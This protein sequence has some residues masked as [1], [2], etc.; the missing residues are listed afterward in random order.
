MAAQS[1]RLAFRIIISAI[2]NHVIMTSSIAITNMSI[3]FKVICYVAE[4]I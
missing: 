1:S 4:K 3:F 2:I